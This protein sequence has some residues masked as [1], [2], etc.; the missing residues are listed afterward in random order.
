MMKRK[1]FIVLV[2]LFLCACPAPGDIEFKD[3]KIHNID[4]KI[5]DYVFVDWKFPGMETTVNVLDGA[6][7]SSPYIMIGFENS[8]INVRGGSISSLASLGSTQVDISGGRVVLFAQDSSQTNISG[9]IVSGLITH[10]SSQVNISGG[11]IE[12]ALFL[13]NHSII[14]IFGYDFA[15]DGQP[16]GYGELT[17]ILGGY[18]HDEPLRHLTGTLL[19]G[20]IIDTDFRIGHDARIALIPE[21]ASALI[22]GLGSLI[23]FLRRKR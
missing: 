11:S 7:M 23:V 13:A 14:Q 17:S 21:P 15:V 4:Y 2:V 8:R 6:R 9:G 22:L 20:E 19:S 18:P 3:G 12:G 5:G 16:F 1:S 10:H